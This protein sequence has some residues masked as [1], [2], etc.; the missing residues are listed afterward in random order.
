M[1]PRPVPAA[2]DVIKENKARLSFYEQY[3][4]R[5][6]INT[7]YEAPVKPEDTCMPHLVYDGLQSQ[8]PPVSGF[9]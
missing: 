2:R 7:A 5:P 3:G 4:A 6:I 1:T 9:C 8:K